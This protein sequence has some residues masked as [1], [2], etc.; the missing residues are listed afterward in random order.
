MA[1][2]R[3]TH[4]LLIIDRDKASYEVGLLIQPSPPSSLTER[5]LGD[6]L[7]GHLRMTDHQL[8]LVPG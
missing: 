8:A 4:C 3:K 2:F 6:K 5:A 1:F 7:F